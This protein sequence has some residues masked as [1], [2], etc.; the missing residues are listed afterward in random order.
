MKYKYYLFN[1]NSFISI[2]NNQKDSLFKYLKKHSCKIGIVTNENTE[3][4]KSTLSKFGLLNHIDLLISKNDVNN[5]K[6]HSEPYIRAISF[7][8]DNLN[9]YIIFENSEIGIKSAKGTG[10]F[11]FEVKNNIDIETIKNI[12]NINDINILIPMAGL[13]SRFLKRGFKKAKPLIEVDKVPMIK[14]AIDSL[15]ING[16]YIFIVRVDENNDKLKKYLYDYKQ[17]C[18]IIEINFLTE[19]SASSCYLAKE[20]INNDK[21]LIISNCDQFL[22]WDSNNF[23]LDSYKRDL[24]CNLLTFESD[25]DKSSFIKTDQNNRGV[26]IR[27]KEVISNNA[28]VGVHYFKK[29]KFFVESYEEIF[30]K[31]IKFKNEYY[32]STVCDNMIKKGYNVSHFL[33]KDDHKFHSLGTPDEYFKF[34]RHIGKLN[35]K[36]N[37][38]DKLK[39]W[40]IGDFK[41]SIHKIKNL[42]VG[43]FKIKKGEKCANHYNKFSKEINLLLKGKMILNDLEINQNDI[44]FVEKE[45]VFCPIIKEDCYI[46]KIKISPHNEDKIIL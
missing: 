37:N 15:N 41:E 8:G 2:K 21:Q 9:K 20:Y 39:G 10:I 27:E 30:E 38:L 40:F 18:K 35:I 19:G 17:N 4:S 34:L 7:F 3:Y 25:F 42:K 26:M 32:L 33:L 36:T 43:Y 16:N 23:L 1:L 6:P 44:F 12:N 5:I 45:E 11:F 28:L 24:D 14:K 31:K 29:G 13:G 46:F 22:E